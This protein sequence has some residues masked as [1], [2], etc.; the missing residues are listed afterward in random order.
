MGITETELAELIRQFQ[1]D[2]DVFFPGPRLVNLALRR[3]VEQIQASDGNLLD[4]FIERAAAE[5]AAASDP[6]GQCTA[7]ATLS[8]NARS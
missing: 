7:H 8:D 5:R 3:K 2:R 1:Q 4:K 6:L